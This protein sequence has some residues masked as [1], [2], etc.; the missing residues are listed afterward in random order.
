MTQ[1]L[2][3]DP[4]VGVAVLP[5]RPQIVLAT[6]ALAARNGE[7]NDH[8]VSGFELFHFL[9]DFDYFAHELMAE[10]VAVL[11]RRHESIEE[12]EIGAAYRGRSDAQDGIAVLQ[13]FRIGYIF[14][15]DV[16]RA[17]PACGPHCVASISLRRGGLAGCIPVT[18]LASDLMISP[19]SISC[20]KRRRAVEGG[21]FWTGGKNL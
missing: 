7:G 4:R 18:A 20:L 17:F 11:H 13:D 2:L 8:A 10:D 1:H 6:P 19:T 3:G 21:G 16:L 15:F 9:S 12:M 5:Q 14:D